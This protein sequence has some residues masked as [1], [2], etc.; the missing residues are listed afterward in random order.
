[1]EH[2]ATAAEAAADLGNYGGWGIAPLAHAINAARGITTGQ[3]GKVGALNGASQHYGQEITKFYA[4]SPGGE[5]ERERFLGSFNGAKSPTELADVL[6]MEGSLIPAKMDQINEDVATTMGAHADPL[7]ATY[8]ARQQAARE[9]LN[10]AI[11]KLRGGAAP[12]QPAIGAGAPAGPGGAMP[13]G[14]LQNEP[15]ASPGGPVSQPG[16]GGFSE[17]TTAVNK[18]TGQRIMWRQGNWVPVQ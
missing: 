9:K 18:Q 1:M 11:A 14:G 17:G 2:L 5:A 7:H 16:S 6:E 12:G 3:A 15:A 8:A 4:G 13:T 10:A